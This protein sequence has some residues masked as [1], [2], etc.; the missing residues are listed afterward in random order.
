MFHDFH[1]LLFRIVDVVL[2]I[3]NVTIL[4]VS[5]LEEKSSRHDSMTNT[6]NQ[7]SSQEFDDELEISK[8]QQINSR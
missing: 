8:T 2:A 7:S 1:I 6:R 5:S 3:V 4:I